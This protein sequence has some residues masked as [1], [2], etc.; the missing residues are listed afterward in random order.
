MAFPVRLLL[1][2]CSASV[3][4]ASPWKG[5]TYA[6]ATSTAVFPPPGATDTSVDSYFPGPAEVGHAG[7]TP[8]A[9]NA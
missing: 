4:L 9:F 6:G 1:A 3:V 5:S 7:P 8:S 2:F